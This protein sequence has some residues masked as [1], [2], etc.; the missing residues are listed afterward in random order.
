MITPGISL[1]ILQEVQQHRM[2]W[3]RQTCSGR[4]PVFSVSR[5]TG[6]PCSITGNISGI[7]PPQA[8][9]ARDVRPWQQCSPHMDFFWASLSHSSLEAVGRTACLVSCGP[10]LSLL[11]ARKGSEILTVSTGGHFFV[12]SWSVAAGSVLFG[13]FSSPYLAG[14][15]CA[16]SSL[17]QSG[18]FFSVDP[19]LSFSATMR[20]QRKNTAAAGIILTLAGFTLVLSYFYGN[21]LLFGSPVIPIAA[22]SALAAF[23]TGAGLIAAAGP[24]TPPVCHFRG[25]PSGLRC[26]GILSR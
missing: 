7:C 5:R 22:I 11:P 17:P 20:R 23:F 9:Y 19:A 24:A 2:L 12:E 26:S 25:R 10:S 3:R 16:A 4:S 8:A 1:L 21:P 15:G 18:S 13:P 14:G 6:G